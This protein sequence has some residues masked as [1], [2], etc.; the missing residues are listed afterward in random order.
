MSI[1]PSITYFMSSLLLFAGSSKLGILLANS[2]LV[3]ASSRS[4]SV[5]NSR[6]GKVHSTDVA[7]H[8]QALGIKPDQ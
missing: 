3:S 2:D 8:E 4:S 5:A 7:L 1:P 6:G